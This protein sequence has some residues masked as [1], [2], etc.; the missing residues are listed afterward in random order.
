MDSTLHEARILLAIKA[1]Q[2][3]S[4]LSTR[5]AAQLYNI[6]RTTLR[7]RL[8]GRPSRYDI[9]P[10]SCKL[11]DLEEQS[12]VQ[13]IL[14][15]CTR[16]FPPRISGVEDMANQLLADRDAPPVGISRVARFQF[17]YLTLMSSYF[18]V[19]QEKYHVFY[20]QSDLRP[21]TEVSLLFP[22]P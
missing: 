8:A 20:H 15:L 5:A 22:E 16:S 6:Q 10:N 1:I 17:L 19:I 13:Y 18:C 11:T 9:P 4:S 3:N 12:I 21:W 7:D 2:N 14:D